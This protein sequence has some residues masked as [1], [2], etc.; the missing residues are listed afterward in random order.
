MYMAS[1]PQ[2]TKAVQDFRV[3]GP[4]KTGAGLQIVEMVAQIAV[5]DWGSGPPR[6][7]H[8]T[9]HLHNMVGTPAGEM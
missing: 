8:H 9:T 3:D 1:K 5:I 6:P 4:T 7:V 2:K